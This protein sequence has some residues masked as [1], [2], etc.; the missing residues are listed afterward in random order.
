M[1][2]RILFSNFL[3]IQFTWPQKGLKTELD[4]RKAVYQREGGRRDQW[5]SKTPSTELKE[6]PSLICVQMLCKVT[7]TF[8]TYK[9][10]TWPWHIVLKNPFIFYKFCN[11]IRNSEVRSQ[12]VYYDLIDFYWFYFYRLQFPQ[13][14]LSEGPARQRNP[15]Q[16]HCLG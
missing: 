1:S 12:L 6:Y 16:V 2:S 11:F 5:S 4:S 14:S 15:H 10:N 9:V 13:S 7:S 8:Y 3:S